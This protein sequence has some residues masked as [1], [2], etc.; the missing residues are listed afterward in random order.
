VDR[1]FEIL[2]WVEKMEELWGLRADEV[3]GRSLFELDIGLP[4]EELRPAIEACLRG[5]GDVAPFAVEAVNRRGTSIH[6]SVV[7]T[8]LHQEDEITGVIALIQ[9]LTDDGGPALPRR[10][11]AGD[12]SRSRKR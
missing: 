10:P 6:C 2:S 9:Q 7:C 11:R 1:Q 12:K 5:Q 4:T 8:P 3:E